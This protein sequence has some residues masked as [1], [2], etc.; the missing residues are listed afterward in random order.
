MDLFKHQVNGID[1]VKTLNGVGALYWDVGCGKTLAALKIYEYYK[2]LDPELKMFVVC[3]VSLIESSWADDIKKFTGLNYANLRTTKTLDANILIVNFE[4]L[5]SRKFSPTLKKILDYGKLMG[6]VDESQ[7]IKSY[8]AKTTKYLLALSRFFKHR[9]LLSGSP[10]PNSKLEYWSQ[11]EF[12][13][14]GLLGKNFFSFRNRFFCL[15]RGTSLIP[16]Q[17]L[18]RKEMMMMMQRGYTMEMIPGVAR[19]LSDKMSP[20]CQ[21]VNKREVLDLPDE[22]DIYRYVEMT[23]GQT[24]AF[25]Q[26]K[27]DLI[28]EIEKEEISVPNALAKLMKLRQISAGFIYNSEGEAIEF[29]PNPKMRDLEDVISEISPD[30]NIIIFCQYR[31]SIERICGVVGPR[32]QALYAGTRSPDEVIHRF[33]NETGRILVAHPASGGV[34]LSF[35]D[36]DYMIFYDLDYS[37]MNYYQCRGRIMRANKKNNA[38]YIHLVAENSLD[39]IIIQ[40][41][42]TKQDND[43]LFRSIIKNAR[44]KIGVRDM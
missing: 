1:Q 39:R 36:C 21:F 12:L 22:I 42:R 16:L 14:P 40:A 37:Y 26:M 41:L 13:R 33:K 28:T 4:T 31:W 15:K 44:T 29:N 2:S 34:G 3:P 8:N 7:R 18:G 24:K 43:K 23:P 19:L 25:K 11:M 5:I 6:V 9:L 32:C 20:Y 30:K 10:A 17:S 38:T 35:N 27:T